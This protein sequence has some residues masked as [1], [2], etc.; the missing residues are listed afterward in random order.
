MKRKWLTAA[1]CLALSVCFLLPVGCGETTPGG[2]TPGGTTPGGTTPGGTT[3]GGTTPGGTTPGG[4]ITIDMYTSVNIIEAEALQV[5]AQAYEDYQFDQ[6][7]DILIEFHNTDDPDGLQRTLRNLVS[8]GVDKPTISTVSPLPEYHGTNKL[9]D[10]SVYLE[11]PNPYSP[12]YETWKDSLEVDAYRPIRAGGTVTIP[13]VSYSSNYACGFYNKQAMKAVMG[14]DPLVDE[15]G[16]IDTSS[17]DFTWEWMLNA[18]EKAQTV[19]DPNW[20]VADPENPEVKKN[21][22]FEYPLAIS[23]NEQ[24]CGQTNFNLV[25]TLVNMYLDQYFRDFTEDVHSLDGEYSFVNS[26]DSNWK[27]DGNDPMVDY[28]S[29]Y[30]YNHNKVV[31]N[32]FNH[33]DEYGPESARYAEMMENLYDL[34]QYASP[35][36]SYNDCFNNFNRTTIQYSKG[37]GNY[38]EMKLFYFETLGYI[39]TYRDAHKSGSGYPSSKW[40]SDSLGWFLMPPM[41]S[42]LEGVA[43]NVRPAGGPLENY[44]VLSTGSAATD[45]IA[46]DF[47]RWLTSPKGQ[48]QITAHYVS[49][50]AP[51]MMHQLVKGVKLDP[52]V[53]YT[54][55]AMQ[56]KGDIG[57]SPYNIFAMGSGMSTCTVG[58]TANYVRDSVASLLSGYFKGNSR[59]WDKGAQMLS[60]LKSGFASYAEQYH[61]IYNDP[62][63]VSEATNGLKNNPFNVTA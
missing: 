8:G 13:G 37:G 56:V 11:E 38:T 27:Y 43:D 24:A 21:F 62:S 35:T 48:E 17:P 50:D 16:T 26:V 3:P 30:T 22:V 32:F 5:A 52:K 18:L 54:Q 29:K 55:V 31:D 61:L 2:T 41:P 42:E 10:L 57:F 47:L 46:V 53:D 60:H 28:E 59:T 40:I 23:R 36:D 9:V 34:L 45:E 33:S 14:D 1:A 6:G 19:G 4:T 49:Q 44:G 15:T 58:N 51:Q 7:K 63:K 12:E 25:T 20:Q 39:R